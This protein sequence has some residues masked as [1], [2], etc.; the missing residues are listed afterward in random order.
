MKRKIVYIREEKCNGCGLCVDACHEGAIE[1]VNGI[2]KLINDTYC[3]GL[4]ACLPECPTGAI[5]IIEREALKF[6]EEAV[7]KRMAE[8]DGA[9]A[10]SMTKAAAMAQTHV[11]QHGNQGHHHGHGGCPGSMTR[12]I[13][14]NTEPAAKAPQAPVHEELGHHPSELQQWPIQISLV[15]PGA[16]FF[17]DANLLIAADCTAFAYADFHRDFIRNHITLIGCP[18]LDDNHY[19]SEKL[20]EILKRNRI[21]SITVVR[22]VVPCCAGIV[23]SVKQ[24]MLNAQMIVPYREVI[25]GIDGNLANHG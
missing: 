17:D 24:A 2:A 12:R 11:H 15:N 8:R 1:L 23:Q 19:Y 21:K 20:T 6:D 5:E 18:K 3:D 16:P 25:V 22:M 4:G 13:E 7:A 9:L 14:R 10:D